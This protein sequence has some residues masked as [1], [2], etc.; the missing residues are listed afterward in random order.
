MRI[1]KLWRGNVK[2]RLQSEASVLISDFFYLPWL[3]FENIDK[4]T[5]H[6]V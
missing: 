3:L 1:M 4:F 2:L 6:K 5:K